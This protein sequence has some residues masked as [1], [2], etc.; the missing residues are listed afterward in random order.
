MIKS[1]N[2]SIPGHATQTALELCHTGKG[3]Y[4]CAESINKYEW[5]DADYRYEM[6]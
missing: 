1:L 6:E 4:P 2:L 3:I 5:E